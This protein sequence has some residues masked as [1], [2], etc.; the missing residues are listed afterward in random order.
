MERK[1]EIT[2]HFMHAGAGTSL[3]LSWVGLI[4]GVFPF[5]ALTV[6]VGAVLALPLLVLGLAAAIVAAPPYGAWRLMGWG[7]RR[8]RRHQPRAEPAP[9]PVPFSGVCEGPR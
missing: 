7:H 4:P 9:L 1:T 5:L 6:L 3:A 2:D 8:R